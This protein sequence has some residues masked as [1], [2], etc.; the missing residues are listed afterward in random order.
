MNRIYFNKN[1]ISSFEVKDT[2]LYINLQHEQITVYKQNTE[3]I[4]E[5]LISMLRGH[6]NTNVAYYDYETGKLVIE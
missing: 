5:K 6:S 3:K 4:I 1:G 2:Y